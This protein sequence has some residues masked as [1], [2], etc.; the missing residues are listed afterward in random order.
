MNG[1]PAVRPLLAFA[2]IALCL[3]LSSCLCSWRPDVGPVEE[4]ES[5]ASIENSTSN[6][7]NWSADRNQFSVYNR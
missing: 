2:L 7:E 6:I 3:G 1:R 5:V 4:E